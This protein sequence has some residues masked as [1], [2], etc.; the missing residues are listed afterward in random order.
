M[1]RKIAN[2]AWLQ[3]AFSAVLVLG[4]YF[5][6]H[7]LHQ[8]LLVQ[9][10]LMLVLLAIVLLPVLR[11]AVF[12]KDVV[13]SPGL[14]VEFG[15]LVRLS[16]ETVIA[17]FLRNEFHHPEFDQYRQQF[18]A[19]VNNPNL[20]STDENALR[21]ALLFL[22]RGAMWRELPD[23]TQWF[24]V[25]LSAADLPRIRVFP[26]AN[27]R[28][29]AEGSFYL[30]DVVKRIAEEMQGDPDDE[31][32][33]KLR[34][35]GPALQQQATL[36]SVLLI[37]VDDK[38]PLTILDGNHRMT[39]ATM[40]SASSVPAQFRFICGYSPRMTECCWYETNMTTLW[41]YA[42]NLVLNMSYD[43]QTDISRFLQARESASILN[44][45]N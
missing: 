31:F 8:V 2:T 29:V 14:P 20:E 12:Q 30:Q 35:L 1:S 45:S 11:I 17:E 9:L 10:Y 37:G 38:S 5:F 32:F 19:L 21:R 13:E 15:H 25:G 40:S 33:C 39:A 6:H 4:I 23:D 42:R 16:E 28:R 43:P 22:R 26:R 44:T 36:S 24:S 3:L 18:E 34:R 27:W 41:R 7:S